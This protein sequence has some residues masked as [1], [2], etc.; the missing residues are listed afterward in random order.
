M[1]AV[2]MKEGGQRKVLGMPG[3]G[4]RKS[5]P[6]KSKSRVCFSCSGLALA[7]PLTR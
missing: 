3:T 1:K 2:S 4:E 7:L 5:L 6:L